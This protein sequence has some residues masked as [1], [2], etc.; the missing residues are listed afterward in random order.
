MLA[1]APRSPAALAALDPLLGAQGRARLQAALL[2][3]A[4][5][6]AAAVTPGRA[7]IAVEPAGAAADVAALTPGVRVEPQAGGHPGERVAAAVAAAFDRH[8]GPV[9][10]AGAGVPR[11]SPAHA[12]AALGD[13]AGGAEASFGPAMDGGWYLTALAAPRPELFDLAA[14]V[15]QGPVVMARTLEV[16]QR[17]GMEVGLL[18]M[19]RRLV[20]AGDARALLADP[21]TPPAVRAALTA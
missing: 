21:L 18:R 8:G 17:L 16:A 15:W 12:A 2:A 4:A 20:T 5:G 19:E 14:E 6:W 13:L 11:L 7:T 10:V 1:D 3:L 9:L